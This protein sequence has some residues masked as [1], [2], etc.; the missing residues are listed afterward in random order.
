[1]PAV[2][3]GSVMKDSGRLILQIA[4]HNVLCDTGI[5]FFHFRK[6]NGKP[7]FPLLTILP[8][9]L[10][11]EWHFEVPHV[12]GSAWGTSTGSGLEPAGSE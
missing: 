11:N 5:D 8:N 4:R 7:P 3:P 9:L 6:V 12:G 1:M 2:I 10:K